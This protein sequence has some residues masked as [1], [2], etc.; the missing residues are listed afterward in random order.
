MRNELTRTG[1][2]IVPDMRLVSTPANE[3]EKGVGPPGDAM[4]AVIG[5][6]MF[7]VYDYCPTLPYRLCRCQCGV[8][9][10]VRE[11]NMRSGRSTQCK[12]CGARQGR[13]TRRKGAAK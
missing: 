1:A 3:A 13:K 9:Q 12:R 10:Y 11:D 8:E 5:P 7:R 6:R 2:A 4:W